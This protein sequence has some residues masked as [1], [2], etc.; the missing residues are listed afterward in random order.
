MAT[1]GNEYQKFDNKQQHQF[2][3]R[4]WFEEESWQKIYF[5]IYNSYLVFIYDIKLVHYLLS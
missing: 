4:D 2:H 1:M 3:K 5:T